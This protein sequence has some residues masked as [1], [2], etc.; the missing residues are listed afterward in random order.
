MSTGLP[1]L[2]TVHP[3]SVTPLGKW[4]L[5]LFTLVLTQVKVL[6]VVVQLGLDLSLVLSDY[7]S[8][9]ELIHWIECLSEEDFRVHFVQG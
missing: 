4:Y 9:L 1:S 5:L 2:S 6:L 3:G 8:C 7:L